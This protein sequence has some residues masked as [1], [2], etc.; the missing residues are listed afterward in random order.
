MSG[1]I[2]K[3]M[4]YSSIALFFSCCS[5]KEEYRPNLYAIDSLVR[6]QAKYLSENKATL[7]KVTR[8]G[9]VHGKVS[10]T[11]KDT[12]AWKKELEIFSTL[13]IINKPVNK[14]LYHIEVVADEKSNLSVKAFTTQEQLPVTYLKVYYHRSP[15]RIRKIEAQYNESN[16]LYKS[17][18]SLTME[19]QQVENSA[20]LTSYSITGGQKMFLGDSVEYNIIGY[21]SISN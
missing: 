19:F 4:L 6:A 17:A 3:I 20:V 10:V 11:P 14:D 1:C 8:L 12:S 18:R 16:S 7:T 21:L 13:D 2:W 5:S 15:D 9:D